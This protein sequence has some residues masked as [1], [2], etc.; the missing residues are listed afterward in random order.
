MSV[1]Y[2][3]RRFIDYKNINNASYIQTE[4]DFDDGFF[5]GSITIHDGINV[6]HLSFDTSINGDNGEVNSS[7]V[8]D[9]IDVLVNEIGKFRAQA[10]E[11]LSESVT[12]INEDV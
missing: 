6:S 9:L 12:S 5:F 1:I 7:N 2:S 10:S 4:I 11:V 3:T 8:I